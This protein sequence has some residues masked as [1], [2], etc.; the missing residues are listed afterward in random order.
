MQE[1]ESTIK[2]LEQRL[3]KLLENYNQ[4]NSS[5]LIVDL[6]NKVLFKTLADELNSG[7]IVINNFGQINY[8]NIV[9]L[10][11]LHSL[12]K[13]SEYKK[14]V[15][16]FA[17]SEQLFEFE[18]KIVA[19]INNPK[20]IR[21]QTELDLILINGR[22]K[23][24]SATVK[25]I[26]NHSDWNLLLLISYKETSLPNNNNEKDDLF[27]S[28]IGV[29]EEKAKHL[30][31]FTDRLKKS[32]EELKEK[33]K[34]KDKF[35]NIIAHDLRAPF[36][37]ILG[38]TEIL[39][40][41]SEE[42]SPAEV[43]DLATRIHKNSENV[44]EMVEDL[45]NWARMQTN[46]IDFDPKNIKISDV[47]FDTLYLLKQTASLKNIKVE[48]DIDKNISVFADQNMINLVLRN[49]VSNAIKF[50]KNKGL[51]KIF[52]YAGDNNKV[53]IGVK[54]NGIGIKEENIKNILTIDE[55]YTKLG[56]NNEK[57]TGLGLVLCQEFLSKNNSKLVIE[58]EFGK[59]STF[60]FEL[61]KAK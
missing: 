60:S 7:V 41:E 1:I 42:L 58:S 10:K 32:E 5:N 31:E 54:D 19:F 11:M 37:S 8:C 26:Q 44:L 29:L 22:K 18:G 2:V 53:T 28:E 52:A 57:G 16:H 36:N 51:I 4:N 14:L 25:A 50:T 15:A 35:F 21:Y 24:V 30:F 59:G 3:T 45:L 38:M 55:H 12:N 13:K 33:N 20:N 39:K 6:D 43:T 61:I 48:T 46:H 34:R 49:L 23:T 9:G 40:L 47:V 27:L 56:T 17:E